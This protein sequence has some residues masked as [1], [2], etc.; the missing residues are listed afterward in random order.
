MGFGQTVGGVPNVS[1]YFRPHD[2][3]PYVLAFVGSIFLIS[4]SFAYWVF[5]LGGAKK[6]MQFRLLEAVGL[7]GNVELTEGR[8]KL[9]AALGPPFVILWVLLA[10]WMNV[11]IPR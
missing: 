10:V 4:V 7:R 5:F 1:H 9:F 8:V 3:N 2:L 11:P 6:A